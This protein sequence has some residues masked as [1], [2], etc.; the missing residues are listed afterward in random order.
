MPKSI[1]VKGL[2]VKEE[3][4]GYDKT[5]S[6][7]IVITPPDF[8]NKAPISDDKVDYQDFVFVSDDYI[9]FS[10]M[11]SIRVTCLSKQESNSNS[12]MQDNGMP[13]CRQMSLRTL[14]CESL[15]FA[16]IGMMSMATA[17][18]SSFSSANISIKRRFLPFWMN[19]WNN[20]M[21]YHSGTTHY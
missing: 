13:Q 12:E 2:S 20:L 10:E 17:C 11:N 7:D 16:K 1:V 6:S 8:F 19:V 3:E 4:N 18:R 9:K 5:V 15:P 14:C 21:Y